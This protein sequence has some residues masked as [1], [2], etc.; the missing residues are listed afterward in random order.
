LFCPEEKGRI[1]KGRWGDLERGS[2]RMG[3]WENRRMG[4][5]VTK[6]LRDVKFIELPCVTPCLTL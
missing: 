2:Q 1:K 4:E 5:K 6:R 3:E